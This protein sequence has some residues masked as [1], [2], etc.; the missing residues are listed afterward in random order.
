MDNKTMPW[1]QAPINIGGVDFPAV[2]YLLSNI[3]KENQPAFI[4][5]H[6]LTLSPEELELAALEAT[7]FVT[8]HDGDKLV[9]AMLSPPSDSNSKQLFVG[10]CD[11][12]QLNRAV[13]SLLVNLYC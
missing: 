5:K 12:P 13:A 2:D 10:D 1:K 6:G 7:D 4:K 3:H 11:D 9:Y 8:F